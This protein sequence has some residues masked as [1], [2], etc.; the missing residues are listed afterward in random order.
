MTGILFTRYT[1]GLT[2]LILHTH[3]H[4]QLL[5]QTLFDAFSE[6]KFDRQMDFHQK[7]CH[8]KILNYDKR[9]IVKS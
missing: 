5:I 4:T 9:F 1:V 8:A 3:T 7:L 2:K 6:H